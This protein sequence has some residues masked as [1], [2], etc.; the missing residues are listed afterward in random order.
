MLDEEVAHFAAGPREVVE[1][2]GRH[3]GLL[4]EREDPP[5]DERRVGR[6]LQDDAVPGDERRGRHARQDRVRKVPGRDHGARPERDVERL[7]E[8]ARVGRDGNLAAPAQHLA[9]VELEE[10]DRLGGLDVGLGPGLADLENH[11]RREVVLP[12]P[13]ACRGAQEDGGALARGQRRPGRLRPVGR[14]DR[15][16]GDLPV[17]EVVAGEDLRAVGGVHVLEEAAGPEAP[18]A[19]D[20]GDLGALLAVYAVQGRL[21]RGALL[22]AAEV[23][24]GFVAEFFEHGRAIVSLHSGGGSRMTVEELKKRLDAGEAPCVLDVREARELAVAAYPF[25]VLHIPMS[26]IPARLDE[27]PGD[28]TVVCACRS[29]SRS[30][31]VAAFLTSHGKDA[32]NLEGGILAW[33]ARI[34]SSIPRY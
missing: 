34:D 19:H 22:G 17:G 14:L 32:V 2:A 27:I 1:R 16:E 24:E 10:V 23:G 28:R 9:R 26:Q 11:R 6:G 21:E 33:S 5:R 31:H 12:G 13:H 7:G 20:D 29:G 3:A 25:P 18:P 30:A 8:L 4:E 15:L